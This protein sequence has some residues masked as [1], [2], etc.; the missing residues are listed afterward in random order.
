MK[1]SVIVTVF[2]SGLV[3]MVGMAGLVPGVASELENKVQAAGHHIITLDVACDCRMGSPAFFEGNRGD[4]W[5][6][7]GK[8]FPAGTLPA[9]TA[10]NDPTLPVNGVGPIG[11]WTCRGQNALPFPS[12]V[13][14]AYN[15]SPVVF[16]TQYFVFNNERSLTLEGYVLPEFAGERLSVTGGVGAFSGAAGYVKEAPFGTNATGCP[17]FRAEFNL[18]PGSV[19]DHLN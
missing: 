19:R 5:I 7:S 13:A 8:I 17:N 11:E 9:G 1:G 4:A 3:I 10:T 2:V 14:A 6:V 12:V 16:N 18:E 15:A